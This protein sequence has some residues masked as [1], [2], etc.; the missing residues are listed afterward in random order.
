MGKDIS[1]MGKDISFIQMKM[2]AATL[3]P[4]FHI[5]VVEGHPVTP[6]LSF[7]LH[8]KHGLKVKVTKRCIWLKSLELLVLYVVSYNLFVIVALC[9]L[10]NVVILFSILE[11]MSQCNNL[12]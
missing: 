2:V 6:K 1:F 8:M 11:I 5:Q 12:L 10:L 3:S 4:K 7:V 9:L